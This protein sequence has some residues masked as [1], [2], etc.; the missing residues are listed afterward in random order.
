MEKKMKELTIDQAKQLLKDGEFIN[1]VKGENFKRVPWPRE[2]ILGRLNTN[3]AFL[4]GD[5]ARSAGYGICS[6]DSEN[7]ESFL[8]IET[9]TKLEELKD[10]KQ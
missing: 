5:G 1:T 7:K 10:G 2:A 4:S 9:I 3:G 8:F 6:P